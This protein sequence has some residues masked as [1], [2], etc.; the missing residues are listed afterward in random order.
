MNAVISAEV[1][2]MTTCKKDRDELMCELQAADF[3]A[4]ELQLFL[5]THP[6]DTRALMMFTSAV[7]KAAMLRN[8]YESMYGPITPA[9]AAGRMPWQ[10]IKSPWNWE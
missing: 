3:A 2:T 9:G 8:E 6:Y 10:W 1:A 5:D 7:Q 4:L